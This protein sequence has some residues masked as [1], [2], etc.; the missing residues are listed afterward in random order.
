MLRIIRIAAQLHMLQLHC[1]RPAV[2]HICAAAQGLSAGEQNPGGRG[3]RC[4]PLTAP[5]AVSSASELPYIV[6]SVLLFLLIVKAR[7]Q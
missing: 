3:I 5:S 7:T 2:S 1:L 4:P 6:L